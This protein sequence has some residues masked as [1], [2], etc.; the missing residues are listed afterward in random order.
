MVGVYNITRHTCN[1]TSTE[2]VS[3]AELISAWYGLHTAPVPVS[4]LTCQ[5][6]CDCVVPVLV[7]NIFHIILATVKDV[8]KAGFFL[9]YT[10]FN[11]F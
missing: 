7:L 5:H 9:P 10:S 6:Q 8:K 4:I 2:V 11:S 1:A 3:P